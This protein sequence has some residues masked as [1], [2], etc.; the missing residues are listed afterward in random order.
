MGLLI[1]SIGLGDRD[2]C[3]NIIQILRQEATVVR[4]DFAIASYHRRV[5]FLEDIMHENKS[6]PNQRPVHSLAKGSIGF[7]SHTVQD[8]DHLTSLFFFDE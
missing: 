4:L 7:P 6:L 2:T 5:P 8:S 1:A 3:L